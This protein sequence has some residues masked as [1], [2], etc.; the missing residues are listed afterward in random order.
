L[1]GSNKEHADKRESESADE[2]ANE[3]EL[4]ENFG[5]Q[6]WFL[7]HSNQFRLK[8]DGITLSRRTTSR[9]RIRPSGRIYFY[10]GVQAAGDYAP[11]G[12]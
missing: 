5:Y 3:S 11:S 6:F 12:A 8:M 2:S 4:A 1:E 9:Q 10:P 7:H